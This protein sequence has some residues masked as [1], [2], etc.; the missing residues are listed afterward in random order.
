M[1]QSKILQP[2]KQPDMGNKWLKTGMFQERDF[3]EF[4]KR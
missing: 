3:R 1:Y 4:Y 2:T